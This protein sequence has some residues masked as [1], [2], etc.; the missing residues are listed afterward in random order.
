MGL[1]RL[2]IGEPVTTGDERQ[3]LGDVVTLA[4]SDVHPG[5]DA[6]T[7][8]VERDQLAVVVVGRVTE[9]VEALQVVQVMLSVCVVL[10][11]DVHQ[12]RGDATRLILHGVR[13]SLVVIVHGESVQL[14]TINDVG[15]VFLSQE[16]LEVAATGTEG[17][18]HQE[19]V[20]TGV[21]NVLENGG[22][23]GEQE[24][25]DVGDDVHVILSQLFYSLY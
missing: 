16:V 6:L 14:H 5:G 15:D 23:L 19:R 4:V 9:T 11:A 18:V 3:E 21:V 7:T 20:V 10:V 25:D 22:L 2:S 8:V 13:V 17:A 1:V 24:V 12:G